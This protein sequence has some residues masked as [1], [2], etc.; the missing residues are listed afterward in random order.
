M[1]EI[2]FEIKIILHKYHDT[3]D[4]FINSSDKQSSDW[5]KLIDKSL[6]NVFRFKSS[7]TDFLKKD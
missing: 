5:L 7:L 4:D 3:L 6:C 1:M 2:K